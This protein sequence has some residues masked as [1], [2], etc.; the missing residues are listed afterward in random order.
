MLSHRKKSTKWL[1]LF[2]GFALSFPLF[3]HISSKGVELGHSSLGAYSTPGID[4]PLSVFV[5]P[6]LLGYFLLARGIIHLKLNIIDVLLLFFVLSNVIAYGIGLMLMLGKGVASDAIYGFLFLGQ[7]LLP[8]SSLYL[9]RVMTSVK[10]TS[11]HFSMQPIYRTL[12]F[13]MFF[14]ALS[15]TLLVL[16]SLISKGLQMTLSSNLVDY[17]GPFH[18]SKFKRYY[19]TILSVV[20]TLYLSKGIFA[21]IQ[22]SARLFNVGVS[23]FIGLTIPFIWSRSAV[24]TTLLGWVML[25]FS[26]LLKKRISRKALHFSFVILGL[27]ITLMLVLLTSDTKVS[28]RFRAMFEHENEI[29]SSDMRRLG[30]N[31]KGIQDGVLQPLGNMYIPKMQYTVGGF[32][33]A[34]PRIGMPENAYLDYAI[35]A[36]PIPLILFLGIFVKILLMNQAL[37]NLPLGINI[38]ENA[39]WV[40][41]GLWA[42]FIALGFWSNFTQLNFTEPYTAFFFW[43][44]FGALVV[45]YQSTK[46]LKNKNSG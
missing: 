5:V 10:D 14:A 34:F 26:G 11:R 16:Q 45:F 18:I 42:S 40:Y 27:V 6:C 41:H 36:G 20:S 37:L 4:F 38:Q 7:T 24:A 23:L 32:P 19:P 2:L 44:L 39:R 43:F 33:Y 17:I 3:L 9:A 28:H 8:I 22:P 12:D 13:A 30:A 21:R 31:I 46:S 25:A 29:A 1:P 15:I 35:K